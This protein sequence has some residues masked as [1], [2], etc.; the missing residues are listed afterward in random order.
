MQT[1]RP[2][3]GSIAGCYTVINLAKRVFVLALGSLGF[4]PGR[5]FRETSLLPEIP[6]VYRVIWRRERLF[7]TDGCDP[8]VYRVLITLPEAIEF[9]I[10]HM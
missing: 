5:F 8:F 9:G 4:L 7:V 6:C 2:L 1:Q 10:I 3:C